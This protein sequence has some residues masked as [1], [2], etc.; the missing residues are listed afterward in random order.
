MK[1]KIGDSF[2]SLIIKCVESFKGK[3]LPEKG[4]LHL[5]ILVYECVKNDKDYQMFNK[6]VNGSGYY[7]NYDELLRNFLIE[8]YSNTNWFPDKFLEIFYQDSYY[9]SSELS[10]DR[11]TYR[12]KG[13][14]IIPINIYSKLYEL[15]K[16]F[17]KDEKMKKFMKSK[18][19]IDYP[20]LRL[21]VRNEIM[22]YCKETY[23][24]IS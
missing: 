13:R 16:K 4:Y 9:F 11:E 15:D 18:F 14:I 7:V 6:F 1:K 5:H 23:K 12:K 8:K 20:E 21:N 24:I 10:K 17:S 2:L 19:A 3:K 22:L